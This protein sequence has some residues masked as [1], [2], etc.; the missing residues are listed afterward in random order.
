MHITSIKIRALKEDIQSSRNGTLM[1]VGEVVINSC[2][3]L[4]GLKIVKGQ[5]G[6]FLSFPQFREGAAYKAFESTSMVFRK[7][8]ETRLLEAYQN[9]NWNQNPIKADD[10]KQKTE[11][12]D[13]NLVEAPHF[14]SSSYSLANAAVMLFEENTSA[15][16]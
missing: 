10:S 14:S 5:Y 8:L 13:M 7:F 16:R 1:A 11:S 9:Q 12:S 15:R 3:L 6:L 2:L 4:R